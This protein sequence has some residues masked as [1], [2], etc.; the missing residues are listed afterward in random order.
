MPPCCTAAAIYVARHCITPTTATATA[1]A[2]AA[3]TAA[4]VIRHSSVGATDTPRIAAASA[5]A[6]AI[7][8]AIAGAGGGGGGGGCFMAVPGR[9]RGRRAGIWTLGTALSV[10]PRLSGRCAEG[11][12]EGGRGKRRGGGGRRVGGGGCEGCVHCLVEF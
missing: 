8:A 1:T 10:W 11:V 4:P 2:A 5:A 3:A 9:V 12:A 6:A 7:A